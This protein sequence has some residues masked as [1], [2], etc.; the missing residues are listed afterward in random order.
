MSPLSDNR[1]GAPLPVPRQGGEGASHACAICRRP[2]LENDAAIN[3]DGVFAHLRCAAH[4]RRG[5][6]T[7]WPRLCA[8]PPGSALLR[9]VAPPAGELA[10]QMERLPFELAASL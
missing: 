8:G 5:G 3:A 2:V 10:Q 4:G 9:D 7:W 6:R 1:S